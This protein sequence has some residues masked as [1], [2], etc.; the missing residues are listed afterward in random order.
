MSALDA[1]LTH[2]R[3]RRDAHLAE[4][5]EFLAIPSVSTLPE[6][7][8]DMRRAAEWLA[9]RLRGLAMERVEIMPTPG[10]P[11]VYGEWLHAPGAPTVL[12]YG[13]YD[14]QPADP[15]DE[16][17]CP[18]FE[19]TVE[20]DYIVARGAS[21]MKGQIFGC[22]KALE[23]IA[24]TGPYPVNLK[25]MLEG[26]EEIGSP[27]IEGFLEQHADRLACDF[28]LNCDAGIHGPQ[29]PSLVCSL[30]GLAYF[31]LHV[32]GPEKDLHSGFFGGAVHNPAQVLCELVAG[33]HDADGRVTLPGFYDTVRPLDEA[34]RAEIAAAAHSDDDIM[35]M[36]GTTALFGE[37]GYT[38]QERVSVRP[39][40]EIN[41]IV[42]GFTGEG[43]KTVLPAKAMAKISCRL[44][45]H[46][47]PAQ[48]AE[49]LHTYVAAHAP[50]TV[51]WEIRQHA[52][53]RP[54]FTERNTPWMRA[55]IAAMKA[56]FGKEPLFMRQGG[57][58]PI[59]GLVKEKLDVDTV[60]MGF[61]LPDDGIHGPNERQYLPNFYI[62]IE[63]YIRF[64]LSLTAAA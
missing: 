38:A 20:G 28:V 45:A 9:D 52:G 54:G 48:V 61:A 62:G 43:S 31:E 12:I 47:D 14:V 64:L 34:E 56:S 60:L 7:N 27:N 13:H 50:A 6:H 1:A 44:V 42:G 11:V 37:K 46:Q 23:A 10:H 19:P 22:L 29:Q 58:I 35:R 40:L 55:A 36:S 39:T 3:D 30:R 4:F 57:T 21:D 15:L 59:V 2:A 33:M 49:Q 25:F 41:G 17:R 5:K 53:A 16:W 26:E 32:R 8:G 51:T 63:T 24:S 18:P